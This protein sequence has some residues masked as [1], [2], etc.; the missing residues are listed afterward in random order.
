[1]SPPSPRRGAAA[2][3]TSAVARPPID[4]APSVMTRSP[5]RARSATRAGHVGQLRHDVHR[6]RPRLV[7]GGG[8]R[9]DRDA[10]NRIFAGG[11]DV[12]QHHFVGGGQR[13]AELRHQ[14]ARARVAMR[15]KRDDDARRL[16]GAGGRQHRGNL[17]RVVTVVVDHRDAVDDAAVFEAPLGAAELRRARRRSSRTARRARG[18]RPRPP[19][20]SAPNDGPAPPASARQAW[21]CR[22]RRGARD[23][24][25]CSAIRSLRAAHPSRQMIGCRCWCRRLSG[26]SIP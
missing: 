9:F 20:R 2:R 12:G 10:G 16:G 21:S 23:A 26:G 6:R 8:Q 14:I 11:V 7:H 15:L 24:R 4:P 3:A 5:G 1:M 17:G 18:R 19:A 13:R 25:W 22:R